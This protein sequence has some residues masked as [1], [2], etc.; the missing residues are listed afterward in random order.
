MIFSGKYKA[1]TQLYEHFILLNFPTQSSSL[2]NPQNYYCFPLFCFPTITYWACFSSFLVSCY[3]HG[4]I[5]LVIL[6]IQTQAS[7]NSE[8]A[9]S[10]FMF[11]ILQKNNFW[12]FRETIM[13]LLTNS[14]GLMS[15]VQ[16]KYLWKKIFFT[17]VIFFYWSYFR[18]SFCVDRTVPHLS[19]LP[20]DT[21]KERKDPTAEWHVSNQLRGKILHWHWKN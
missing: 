15:E 14:L 1:K 20:T 2:R 8:K 19:D 6:E 16:L 17:D 10:E 12:L 9:S 3:F 4:G 11:L 18:H 7:S 5:P 13:S 21:E